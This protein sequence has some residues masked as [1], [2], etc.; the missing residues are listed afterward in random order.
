MARATTA[1]FEE[2]FLEVETATPGTYA[3]VCG[4]V[5]LEVTFTVNTDETLVPDCDDESLPLS[6]TRAG[7]STEWSASG[8]GVWAQS[9]HEMLMQWWNLASVKNIRLV[10]SKASVGDVEYVAGAA[11][12]TSLAHA[13]AKGQQV[14]A[15]VEIVSAGPVTLTDQT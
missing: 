5:D 14:S 11:L 12:M 10:Y 6:I 3:R 4:L 7:I 1:K 13:R 9:S 8:T 2:M 15:A